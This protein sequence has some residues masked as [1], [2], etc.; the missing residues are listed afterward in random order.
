MSV[1]V[2]RIARPGPATAQLVRVGLAELPAPREDR[3]VVDDQ[4]A[5]GEQKGKSIK[6]ITLEEH[7]QKSHYGWCAGSFLPG[8]CPHQPA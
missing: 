8:K 3:L 4:P 7:F 5:P 6:I 1:Q 2:P